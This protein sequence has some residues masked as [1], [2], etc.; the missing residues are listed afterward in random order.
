MANSNS[1]WFWIKWVALILVFLY[2]F[3]QMHDAHA[4]SKNQKPSAYSQGSADTSKI[5]SGLNEM[6][7]W[8]AYLAMGLGALS[9]VIGLVMSAPIIGAEEKGHK[10]MKGGMWVA[11][12]GSLVWVILAIL[13][14]I[15]T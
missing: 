3:A 10:A 7:S 9:A 8:A 2:S 13:G 5:D 12:G 14:G 6:I 4:I 15:F 11:I 1:S